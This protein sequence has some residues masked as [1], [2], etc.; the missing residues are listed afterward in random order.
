M[1]RVMRF[2][3]PMAGI[4]T[5]IYTPSTKSAKVQTNKVIVD[6]DFQMVLAYVPEADLLPFSEA[7][8]LAHERDAEAASQLKCDCLA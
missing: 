5:D 8:A 4:V 2:V 1:I 3:D 7:L 6:Y